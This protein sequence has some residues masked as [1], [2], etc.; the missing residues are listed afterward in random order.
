M[1]INNQSSGLIR[2]ILRPTRVVGGVRLRIQRCKTTPLSVEEFT[3]TTKTC[4]N[5]VL[6]F[7][8]RVHKLGGVIHWLPFLCT[9]RL[10]IALYTFRSRTTALLFHT[11][12]F[13]FL[14]YRSI[15]LLYFAFC[16]AIEYRV[17]GSCSLTDVRFTPPDFHVL[18]MFFCEHFVHLFH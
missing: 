13:N 7:I 17:S 12:T 11:T 16:D 15:V 6:F 1:E 5:V 3:P 2:L 4:F 8:F 10:R 18:P 14:S 9:G